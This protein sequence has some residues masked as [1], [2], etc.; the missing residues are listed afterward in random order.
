MEAAGIGG[1]VLLAGL[2]T[3]FL[4]HPSMPVMKTWL[5]HYPVLRR[6]ILGVCIGLYVGWTV[7]LFGK[8]S[9]AHVN[10]AVTWTFFRLRNISLADAVCYVL[11][12]FI[13]AIIAFYLLKF[14][15]GHLFSYPLIDY[16]VS[17]PQPPHTA[18]GAFIAEFVISFVLM[19]SLLLISSSRKGE[20]YTAVVSGILLALYIIIELPYSGMSM[21]PARSFAAALG[22]NQWNHL[23]IYFI[24]PLAAMLLAAEIFIVWKKRR[25]AMKHTDYKDI[26]MYPVTEA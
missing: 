17:K 16:G 1:F 19:M 24:S 12:Q 4:E 5:W 13:G 2:L 23:W 20:K 8:L 6:V 15:V 21:N 10:P 7:K 3:I 22:A 25:I 18:T 11:A 9:G 26:G 14:F